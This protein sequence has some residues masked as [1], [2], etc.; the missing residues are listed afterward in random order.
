MSAENPRTPIYKDFVLIQLAIIVFV[1]DQFSKLIVR[2]QLLFRESFP[3]TGFFR[4]THT[5]NTGSAFGIF[6]DQNTPLILVSAIGIAILVLIYRSQRVPTALLRLSLGLQV[7]GAFGNLIDRVRLGHVT[8]FIDVGDWPIFNMADASIITGLVIMA[9]IF[10]I[11]DQGGSKASAPTSGYGWCPVCEG[12]MRTVAGGWRCST[13]GVKE[14]LIG[15][16]H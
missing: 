5:F 16:A 1:I 14:R 4:F 2:D 7:G 12:E 9:Y 11:A 13:C 8:D 3:D 6:Q 15:S 10:L